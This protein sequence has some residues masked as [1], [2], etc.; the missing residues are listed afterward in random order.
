MNVKVTGCKDCPFMHVTENKNVVCIH[1]VSNGEGI[2]YVY[3]Q[4]EYGFG[5][6]DWCP[7]NKEPITIEKV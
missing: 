4:K 2:K 3:S 6:P 1:P 7:L 5:L